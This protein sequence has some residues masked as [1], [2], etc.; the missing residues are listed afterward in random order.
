MSDRNNKAKAM[1]L[2][3]CNTNSVASLSWKGFNRVQFETSGK[4]DASQ[5]IAITFMQKSF[6]DDFVVNYYTFP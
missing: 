4:V 1:A 3:L 5:K 6:R 2:E